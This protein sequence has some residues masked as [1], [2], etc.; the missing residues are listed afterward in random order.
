[1]GTLLEPAVE[2]AQRRLR[3][4][5]DALDHVQQRH[6]RAVLRRDVEGDR[7]RPLVLRAEVERDE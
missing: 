5:L 3:D 7:Q 4:T 6:L 2:V 1:M